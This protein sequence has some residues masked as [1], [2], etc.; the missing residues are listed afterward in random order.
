MKT[1]VINISGFMK[2][3]IYR[4]L[5]VSILC[6]FPFTKQYAADYT[7]EQWRVVEI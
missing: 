4:V 7:V 1:T 6:L 2:T 5:F 3:E